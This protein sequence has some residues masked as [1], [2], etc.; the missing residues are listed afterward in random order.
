M[1]ATS[2]SRGGILARPDR[3][4]PSAPSGPA[5]LPAVTPALSGDPRASR[6]ALAP[7]PS[8]EGRRAL[9]L[10][11]GVGPPLLDAHHPRFY[12]FQAIEEAC[13]LCPRAER[14]LLRHELVQALGYLG[15]G[16][17]LDVRGRVRDD[18][19]A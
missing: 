4:P 2:V 1:C 8:P 3:V 16:L 13:H 5:V 7:H 14:D 18:Q 15:H 19:V 17:V 10:L 11:L 12:Q 9:G 6:S